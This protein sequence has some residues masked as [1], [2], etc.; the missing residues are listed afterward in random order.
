M[1]N[2]CN[3]VGHANRYVRRAWFIA[4][5]VICMVQLLPIPRVVGLQSSSKSTRFGVRLHPEDLNHPLLESALIHYTNEVRKKHELGLCRPDD[6]LRS[7]ALNHS[8]ELAR[9]RA[10]SHESQKKETRRLE[11][12]LLM[13]GM[14]LGNT[15]MGENLGV[16]YYL[17]IADIPFYIQSVGGRKKI[18][19]ARTEKQIPFQTYR[20]FAERMVM[21]WMKSPGHRENIL[22]PR[23]DRIGI[24][25][26]SGIF[27]E[28]QALYVT[29]N[30]IGPIPPK[31]PGSD[32]LDAAFHHESS[33]IIRCEAV[34]F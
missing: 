31:N 25:I 22:N 26:V 14:D 18:I 4:T 34:S 2:R 30:F 6:I 20:S 32:G 3:F 10:L 19:D 12:R 29:Q 8:S 28:F 16:D 1:L 15:V 17:R 24:G 21:N 23:F 27:R 7:A 13:A 33:Q 11:D 5:I 9:R